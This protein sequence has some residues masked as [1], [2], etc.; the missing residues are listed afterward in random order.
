[1]RKLP[2]IVTRDG[3]VDDISDI[4]LTMEAFF[5]Y[6]GHDAA[7]YCPHTM[8]A[9]CLE[10]LLG[11]PGTKCFVAVDL[12]TERVVG[13]Y[14]LFYQKKYSVRPILYEAHFAVQP[15]YVISKAA[16]KLTERAIEFGNEVN[17]LTFYAGATSGI[18]RFDKSL[19]NLYSKFGMKPSGQMMRY[20]Y[21]KI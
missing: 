13:H 18:K 19:I 9:S 7:D 10:V 16:R 6:S 20:D 1:M 8:Q 17:A 5:A 11:L 2:R 21:G 15:E 14:G 4:M 3:N 12:D